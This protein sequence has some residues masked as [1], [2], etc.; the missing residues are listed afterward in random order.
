MQM[1]E[2]ADAFYIIEEGSVSVEANFLPDPST[3]GSIEHPANVLARRD[4]SRWCVCP[5]SPSR[6][7]PV[8]HSHGEVQNCG[9]GQWS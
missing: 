6:W 3:P 2:E 9:N 8:F 1:G 5:T 7:D 4:S